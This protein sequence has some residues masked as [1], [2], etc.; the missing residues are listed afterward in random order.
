MLLPHQVIH[1]RYRLVQPLPRD[2]VGLLTSTADPFTAID[3]ETGAEVVLRLM[4]W[5]PAED[6]ELTQ[7]RQ[8][9]FRA[10]IDIYQK[11]SFCPH[12]LAIRDQEL[13]I[14]RPFVVTDP[15]GIAAG[16][17]RLIDPS[18]PCSPEQVLALGLQMAQCL[19][20]LHGVEADYRGI[21]IPGLWHGELSSNSFGWRDPSA[22]DGSALQESALVLQDLDIV[23][24][25][26]R[27]RQ[28][29]VLPHAPRYAAPERW[30]TTPD[31]RSDIYSLGILL[32]ELLTGHSPYEPAQTGSVSGDPGLDWQSIHSHQPVVPLA[33]WGHNIPE[34][35]HVLVMACLAKD[36][37]H[38]PSTLSAVAA[39]LSALIGSGA[40]A[41]S[42]SPEGTQ[43]LTAEQL[44]TNLS[45]SGSRA[46]LPGA[47]SADGG[48]K[49][50][51]RAFTRPPTP[52]RQDP[53]VGL[54]LNDRYQIEK[55]IGKG[56]MGSVYLGSDQSLSRQVA[57]KVMNSSG[58]ADPDNEIKRF[59]RE[60]EVCGSLN[61]PNIVQISDYGLTPQGHPYYVMEY[62]QGSNLSQVIR[63]EG[64]LGWERV[65]KV[66]VQICAGLKEA[67]QHNIVHRD[68]KPD[69]IFLIS[70]S[71]G[72]RVKILDFGIAKLV[73]DQR[74]TQLTAV[75]AFLGTLR[76][77]APEQCGIN[78][79]IDARTDLYALGLM[80]YEML[81]GTNPFGVDIEAAGFNPMDWIN[82][83]LNRQPHP[84]DRQPDGTP[85]PETIVNL[86]MG[87]LAKKPANRIQS[88]EELEKP[89]RRILSQL[90]TLVSKSELPKDPLVPNW[91]RSASASISIPE[92]PA[93]VLPPIATQA[94]PAGFRD[95]TLNLGPELRDPNA[96]VVDMPEL[97][98]SLQPLPSIPEP[99]PTLADTGFTPDPTATVVQASSSN[100][101]EQA[102]HISAQ[103]D[104]LQTIIQA[105]TPDPTATVVQAADLNLVAQARQVAAQP[106]PLQTTLQAP[107]AD[108]TA[109]VV[110]AAD[111]NLVAQA[112][113]VAAQ[114]DPL[115]TTIQTPTADP[116][117]TVVQA[118]GHNLV[119]QARQVEARLDPV[120]K[121]ASSHRDPTPAQPS[122]P[123]AKA[124]LKPS[125]SAPTRQPSSQ[126]GGQPRMSG[127]KPAPKRRTPGCLILLGLAAVIAGVMYGTSLVWPEAP[128]CGRITYLCHGDLMGSDTP[129]R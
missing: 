76:Y 60:V 107:K 128:W 11:L 125:R 99:N 82:C 94:D 21:R 101:V 14:E 57:I 88:V 85:I 90:P 83:H 87:C 6:P 28:K 113:Q 10:E 96:T 22:L 78:K 97:A 48:S 23:R 7:L 70:G 16:L 34:P 75:G 12:L 31:P 61:S 127:S 120:P 74:R 54:L 9:S 110:Q 5:D 46:E 64:F 62:L 26:A 119:D 71:L 123:V 51:R 65:V 29:P 68:L 77:A 98:A 122:K 30:Q 111:L 103:P 66:V 112:R 117:A 15:V 50:G 80:I 124:D 52:I 25:V 92:P 95:S 32:Y 121:K 43:Q 13:A 116:T 73:D 24:L 41:I 69:N 129:S 33:R 59:K 93:V 40:A 42:T 86:V 8:Q 19:A 79:P 39:Q 49:S 36:P 106:D 109:T 58:G 67:H 108:P 72:E 3:T 56:G 118:P 27:L 105:P 53:Y 18:A 55:R 35:L 38:R 17:E 115:Q 20:H 63:S 37:S 126:A 104:P 91:I 2:G 114:P 89:F 100:L 47:G 102:R 4:R 1:N 84:L 45:R 44:S 81:T